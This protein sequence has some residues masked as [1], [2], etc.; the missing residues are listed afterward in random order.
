MP[1]PPGAARRSSGA[2]LLTGVSDQFSHLFEPVLHL[3][4][5]TNLAA[6]RFVLQH[7]AS[8]LARSLTSWNRQNIHIGYA[9]W[10]HATVKFLRSGAMSFGKQELG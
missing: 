6:V 10:L 7:E 1:F 4:S 8:V 3:V 2:G 9:Y 5:V